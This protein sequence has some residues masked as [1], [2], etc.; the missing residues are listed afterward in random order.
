V[1]I[2]PVDVPLDLLGAAMTGLAEGHI[3]GKAMV[4][5]HLST[6]PNYRT[7]PTTSPEAS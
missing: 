6:D 1:L 5:P 2:D 4:V 3:A 7:Q